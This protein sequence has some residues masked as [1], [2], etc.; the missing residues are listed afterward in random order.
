MGKIPIVSFR[1]SKDMGSPSNN[2][3][4]KEPKRITGTRNKTANN[5]YPIPTRQISS[6]DSN[7]F[8]PDFPSNMAV[9]IIPAPEAERTEDN[10]KA[11]GIT[12]WYTSNIM[13]DPS[14]DA[15]TK[16]ETIGYLRM[17]LNRSCAIFSWLCCPTIKD[18]CGGQCQCQSPVQRP[19]TSIRVELSRLSQVTRLFGI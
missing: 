3:L 14:S 16:N 13:L 11:A 8:N 19:A 7:N 12:P 4:N 18:W 17:N 5:Q 10:A 15:K 2:E 1:S 6:R 9:M